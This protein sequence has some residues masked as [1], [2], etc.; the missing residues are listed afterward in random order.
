MS[1]DV[2]EVRAAPII[3]VDRLIKEAIENELHSNNMNREDVPCLTRSWKQ[4][5]HTLKVRRNPPLKE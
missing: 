4:L 1:N 3:N 2:S 5:I